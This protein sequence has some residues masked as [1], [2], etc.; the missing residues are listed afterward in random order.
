MPKFARFRHKATRK[1]MIDI[2]LWRKGIFCS[3]LICS[4]IYSL[5]SVY[6]GD[7]K[8]LQWT[9]VPHAWNFFP[10]IAVIGTKKNNTRPQDRQMP[11]DFPDLTNL[12][13]GTPKPFYHFLDNAFSLY[14]GK[15]A[16]WLLYDL[17]GDWLLQSYVGQDVRFKGFF[18]HVLVFK[19][20]SRYKK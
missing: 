10:G 17:N 4:I 12:L 3:M 15:N 6:E 7:H 13:R 16:E 8:F 2:I 5:I 9:F 18:W 19:K 14:C 1:T 20:L 11:K